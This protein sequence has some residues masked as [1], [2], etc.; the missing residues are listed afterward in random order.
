MKAERTPFTLRLT[1]EL[2]ERLRRE[3]DR[4]GVSVNCYIT[5][6]LDRH[7]SQQQA[8]KEERQ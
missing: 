1:P 4:V 6:T 7:L 2:L 8:D 5:M 3:A